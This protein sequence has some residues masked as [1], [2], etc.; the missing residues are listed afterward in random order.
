[1]NDPVSKL[2]IGIAD[3][4]VLGEFLSFEKDRRDCAAEAF[5]T[6]FIFG[7]GPWVAEVPVMQLGGLSH[8]N[9]IRGRLARSDSLQDLFPYLQQ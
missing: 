9:V 5:S 7:R 3:I 6:N 8:V 4:A 1:M 2:V